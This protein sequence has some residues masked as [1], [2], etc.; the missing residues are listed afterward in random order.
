MGTFQIHIA[1][2][3]FGFSGLFGNYFRLFSILNET[4]DI[5]TF[6]GGL[7]IIGTSIV[8]SMQTRHE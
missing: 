7:I 8:A 4:P 5:R 1:V 3:L 6:A 2:F